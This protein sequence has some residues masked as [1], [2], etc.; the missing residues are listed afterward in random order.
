MHFQT[1][2]VDR[3]EGAHPAAHNAALAHTN[4]MAPT[5]V[6]ISL[7]TAVGSFLLSGLSL[8]LGYLLIVGGATGSFDFTFTAGEVRVNL[9]AFVPGIAFAGFGMVIAV[10]AIRALMG[11]SK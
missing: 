7:T 8:V 10:V 3:L 11:V 4:T 6:H 2:L 5:T 1:Q 9:F